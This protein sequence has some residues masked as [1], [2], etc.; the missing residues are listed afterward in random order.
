MLFHQST[1]GI[2]N[3]LKSRNVP[4]PEGNSKTLILPV[5][6]HSLKDEQKGIKGDI[7]MKK[8]QDIKVNFIVELNNTLETR[9]YCSGLQSRL[10][11]CPLDGCVEGGL[12]WIDH[13]SNGQSAGRSCIVPVEARVLH[14]DGLSGFP[15]CTCLAVIS[16]LEDLG[17]WNIRLLRKKRRKM[18]TRFICSF[19]AFK[20][21]LQVEYLILCN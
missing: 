19:F 17:L 16:L 14:Q 9:F 21:M 5:L 4:L 6:S 3:P 8:D 20:K 12:L 15:L 1:L 10:Q 18:L 2:S 11:D 13:L 7:D